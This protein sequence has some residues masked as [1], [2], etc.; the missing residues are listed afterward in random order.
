MAHAVSA[1]ALFYIVDIVG[2]L[3]LPFAPEIKGRLL[4][5]VCS[6]AKRHGLRLLPELYAHD[7]LGPRP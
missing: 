6:G 3:I 2:L 1:V 7:E 4:S 5:Q